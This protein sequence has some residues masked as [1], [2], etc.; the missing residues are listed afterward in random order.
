LEGSG[1]RLN[2]Y[3]PE[4]L[5]IFEVIFPGT[6]AAIGMGSD[7]MDVGFLGLGI[8]GIAMARNLLKKGFKVTVWNR[9]PGKV[10]AFS[11]LDVVIFRFEKWMLAF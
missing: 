7:G 3:V 6:F 10:R 4:F 5:R 9:S 8:M 2:V 11:H 1:R